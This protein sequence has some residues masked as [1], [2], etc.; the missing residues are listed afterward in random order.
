MNHLIKIALIKMTQIKK[1]NQSAIPSAYNQNINPLNLDN[2]DKIIYNF[3]VLTITPI[4]IPETQLILLN[5][6]K[7][8][9]KLTFH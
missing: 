9:S 4:K 8:N 2:Q 6:Q 3:K 1:P 5:I 7:I